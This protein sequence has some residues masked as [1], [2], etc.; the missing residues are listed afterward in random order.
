MS[1]VPEAWF[2]AKGACTDEEPA[3]PE[4]AQTLQTYLNGMMADSDAA[5]QLMVMDES[6]TPL[7]N[8]MFR[9]ASLVLAAAIEF[10]DYQMAVLRLVE[11]IRAIPLAEIG[12]TAEQKQRHPDWGQWGRFEAFDRL[13]DAERRCE[14]VS[15]DL[16]PPT[17]LRVYRSQGGTRTNLTSS[18]PFGPTEQSQTKTTWTLKTAIADGRISMP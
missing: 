12:F 7:G 13:V 8:K 15:Y 4:E 3:T 14:F 9:L 2:T 11:A 16:K 5:R 17:Q 18:Q 1:A 10:P 6:R